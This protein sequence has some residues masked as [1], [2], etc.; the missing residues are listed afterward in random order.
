MGSKVSFLF[1]PKQTPIFCR[2]FHSTP[3]PFIP[4]SPWIRCKLVNRH[5]LTFPSATPRTST[6]APATTGTTALARA[7]G[8]VPRASTPTRTVARVATAVTATAAATAARVVVVV[9]TLAALVMA[10]GATASTLLA[11]P[12]RVLSVSCLVR[13]TTRRSSTRASTLKST[14]TFL[15]RLRATMSP[16]PSSPSAPLLWMSTSSAT[17]SWPTTRCP[18]PCKSTPSPSSWVVVI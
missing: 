18:R 12:T 6:D 11:R 14:T 10:S 13:P 3:T 15:S 16:S 2:V 7:V 5:Q 4:L 9:A 17:L 1:F 8:T